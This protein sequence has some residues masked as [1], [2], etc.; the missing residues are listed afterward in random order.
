MKKGLFRYI[1][2][3]T[4]S[5]FILLVIYYDVH[6]FLTLEYIKSN[7]GIFRQYYQDH[8][9]QTL[10]MFFLLYVLTTALSLPGATILTLFAGGV[11]GFWIGLFLVSFA[12]SIGATLA[13]LS[14]RYIFSEYIQRK[15][16][17]NLKSINAGFEK[18]GAFYLFSLRL[19]PVFPFFVINLVLGVVP[20]KMTTFY[21]VSQLGMLAGTIVYVNAGLQLSKITSL[22]NILSFNLIA[23]FILLGL[24]P[25]LAKKI[26]YYYKLS[27]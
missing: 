13:F 11:F 27:I 3:L 21:L 9:F 16:G 15:F 22:E 10:T 17:S 19:I 24:F 18:A 8:Q 7:Q 14:S 25:L 2:L 4:L 12:S 5:F 1:L 6:R 26:I 20:I 23:S